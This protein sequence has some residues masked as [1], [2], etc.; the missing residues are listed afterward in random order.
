MSLKK[1][2]M[3]NPTKIKRQLRRFTSEQRA[4]YLKQ[5][6]ESGQ[7][8]RFFSEE[9]GLSYTSFNNWIRR[10]KERQE[11]KPSGFVALKVKPMNNNFGSSKFAEVRTA[12][13]AVICLY[14]EVPAEYLQSIARA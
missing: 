4:T 6:R 14:H 5:W 2:A 11:E 7:S 10:A 12:K 3:E 8:Q 9:Q 13:G 1:Q